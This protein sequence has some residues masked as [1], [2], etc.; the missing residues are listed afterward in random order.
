MPHMPERILVESKGIDASPTQ[1]PAT[2]SKCL[3]GLDTVFQFGELDTLLSLRLHNSVHLSDSLVP[4]SL[5]HL[6][7]LLSTLSHHP[8]SCT[9]APPTLD[10]G[11]NHP[12][13]R[14]AGLPQ[15]VG[16]TWGGL[17]HAS[18]ADLRVVRCS[19]W[20]SPLRLPPGPPSLRLRLLPR[21]LQLTLWP[22]DL[23]LHLGRSLL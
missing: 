13:F 12:V 17:H 8:D 22:L 3:L 1:S 16:S 20:F 19:L 23:H 14:L 9:C 21:P 2:E 6:G 15:S 10:S 4:P 7:C 5:F 18:S 11:V